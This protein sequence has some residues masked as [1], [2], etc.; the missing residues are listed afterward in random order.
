MNL[1]GTTLA[2]RATVAGGLIAAFWLSKPLWLS[3]RIYPFTPVWTFWHPM[4]PP[5]DRVVFAAM[6]LSLVAIAVT[7][8]ATHAIWAFV[9][10]AAT[11]ALAD[12]SR[13]QPWFYQYVFML[14]ALACGRGDRSGAMDTCRLIVVSTYFWSGV[15]KING[16]FLKDTF[17]TMVAPLAG[18]HPVL[19]PFLFALGAG[20][21]AIEIAIALGLL[22]RRTR[23]G[24]V[25]LAMAM[26]LFVLLA[27]G[28]LGAN[29][30]SVVWPWNVAMICLVPTLFWNTA[31]SA[32]DVL[33][34]PRFAFQRIV[35]V[36][37]TMAPL[38]SLC[39]LWDAYLSAALYSSNKN[40]ATIRI[41]DALADRLPED[42]QEHVTVGTGPG[43]EDELD[44]DEWSFADLH[45][46]PYPEIRV[47]R[48]V[49]KWVCGFA[50]DPS[51]VTLVI[52][53]RKGLLPDRGR[54]TW[55]CQDLAR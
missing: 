48:S 42:V 31:N 28:P 12:Q 5:W 36:L 51:E 25:L 30:N 4:P 3:S 40:S 45:V 24:A 38:L 29:I 13:W 52:E 21:P 9:L 20:A 15:Q 14:L 41:S 39:N 37:F 23:N 35:L 55:S 2:L 53:R 8:R 27:I 50:H 49:T 46:P 44:V 32:R 7:P 43:K 47:F 26:H 19:H 54:T 22:A 33:W 11:L 16:S 34:T 10:L 17:Q 6:L 1:E 18:A